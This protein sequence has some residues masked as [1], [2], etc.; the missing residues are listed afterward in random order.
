MNPEQDIQAQL[1]EISSTLKKWEQEP[2]LQDH[3]HNGF[4]S[5]KIEYK[6]LARKKLYINHCIFGTQAATA[7]NYGV[8]CIVPVACVLTG[9]QEV[10]RTAGSDAGTVTVT[11][12]KLTG[13]TAPDSGSVM[14]AAVLSLKA[15]ANTV[16]EGTLSMTLTN[17]TLAAGDRLCLKDAGTL[18]AVAD[19]AVKVELT[20]V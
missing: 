8:F 18:T 7:G 15:T 10:H 13:T 12:E 5:T 6:D 9:F 4:D 14:L 2:P 17:R 1:D 11:L 3:Q 20:V 16:Q 19:V